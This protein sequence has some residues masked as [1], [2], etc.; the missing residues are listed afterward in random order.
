MLPSHP[1]ITEQEMKYWKK[2]SHET[3]DKRIT[4]ALAMNIDFNKKSSMG[5]PASKL[6]SL[7]FHEGASFLKDAPL[8]RSYVQNPNH[9]GCHTLGSSEAFFAGTQKIEAEVIDI[10]SVDLLGADPYT[11]DGYVASGGTE[12]NIQAIWIYRNLFMKEY[13]LHTEQ[14]ALLA[15]EDSHYSVAKAANLLQ[16]QWYPVPVRADDRSIDSE[17][18][19]AV[20][21]RLLKDGIKCIIVMA[22][23]GTTMYG[24]VDDPDLYV[25]SIE[26]LGL[27]FRMHVDGAFGGFIYPISSADK[28]LSFANPQISSMT[29]D[30]HKMLQAPYGTGIFL[31]RKGLMQHVYT[32]EAQYVNGMD[33][34]LSGSR[35]GANAIAVWMILATYGPYG[36]SEKIQKLI[37]RTDWCC[38]ELDRLG[39]RYYRHPAMNI[40]ALDAACIPKSLFIKYGLVPD[41]HE[42][43]ANWYKIVVMDHVDIDTLLEFIT[44]LEDALLAGEVTSIINLDDYDHRQ[45]SD[46]KISLP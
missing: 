17:A 45:N 26:R 24:S 16:L 35:S 29:L 12:A 4:E 11:C 18:L 2:L 6:D 42:G 33:I 8:L 41:T 27:P 40:I 7:V 28:R 32:K 44:E 37:Q 13:S 1:L 39:I 46:R 34:T 14:I 5:I 3:Q 36:Y 9:I 25:T 21:T 20:L 38:R 23:M 19:D 15:S 43:N 10:L 31:A 30:A 22:N